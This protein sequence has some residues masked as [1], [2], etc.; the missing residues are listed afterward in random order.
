MRARATAATALL[1]AIAFAILGALP[2]DSSPIGRYIVL[3]LA[4]SGGFAC[5]PPLLAWL[6]ANVRGTTGATLSI[7]LSISVG[8]IGQV[9]GVWYALLTLT[10]TGSNS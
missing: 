2:S 8:G 3:I 10:C 1:A 6:S 4:N 5:A 7:P 9:I